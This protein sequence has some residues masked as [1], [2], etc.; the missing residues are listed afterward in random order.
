MQTL[1]FLLFSWH[2]ETQTSQPPRSCSIPS[3]KARRLKRSSSWPCPSC[4]LNAWTSPPSSFG[5]SCHKV[6]HLGARF[7]RALLPSPC[8]TMPHTF[9]SGSGRILKRLVSSVPRLV[10]FSK[11]IVLFDEFPEFG[12]SILVILHPES[13]HFDRRVAKSIR[14]EGTSACTGAQI[15]LTA[16]RI[17]GISRRPSIICTNLKVQ[18]VSLDN[19][20]WFQSTSSWYLP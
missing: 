10:V 11:L 6:K 19:L 3:G 4:T 18:P 12:K 1:S 17:W 2:A 15:S 8:S 13:L 9:R 7:Q 16:A 14:P 20:V 5:R